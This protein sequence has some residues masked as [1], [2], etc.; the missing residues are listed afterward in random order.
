M[1]PQVFQWPRCRLGGL[2]RQLEY[3]AAWYGRTIIKIDK[4]YP[5]SKRC[6]DCGYIMPMMPLNVRKWTCSSECGETYSSGNRTLSFPC[7]RLSIT[8]CIT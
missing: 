1:K 5:S 2:V 4:F 7:R 8:A 6:Y 3:K